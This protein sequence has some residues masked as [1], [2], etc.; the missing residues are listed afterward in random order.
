M[1]R[2]VFV[3]CKLTIHL[4]K[5]MNIM[6]K[7]ALLEELEEKEPAEKSIEIRSK[8]KILMTAPDVMES[9]NRLECAEGESVWVEC[10][11]MLRTSSNGVS[12]TIVT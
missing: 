6:E 7:V 1:S 4:T 3:V 9:L 11:N 5:S 10:F 12:T 8:I 2:V